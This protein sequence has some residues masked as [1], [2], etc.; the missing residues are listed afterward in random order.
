[1]MRRPE[2]PP[3]GQLAV[4]ERAGDRVDQRDLEQLGRGQ[5]RQN[6]G[7]ARGQH[8]LAGAGRPVEQQRVRPGGGDLERALGALLALDV[9]EVGQRAG[10]LADR[11]ARA[12]HHLRAGKVVGEL[13]QR[14][15]RQH[16]HVGRGPRR[17][18]PRLLRADQAEAASVGGHRRGQHAD[19]GGERA[20]Q[21]Q[22]AEHD[23]GRQ[24]VGRQG[25]DRRHD[26]ERDRQVVMTALLGQVGGRE[27]DD[28]ALGRQRQPRGE[29]RRAH[30]LLRFRDRLV[31]EADNAEIDV[32]ARYLDLDVD[33]ARLDPLERHGRNSNNH[34][35]RP[36]PKSRELTQGRLRLATG[37]RGAEPVRCRL[38]PRPSFE[39][40]R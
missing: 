35:A 13:D 6:R 34:R 2:R 22:L 1:M 21:R 11:R 40:R 30:P 19:D 3:V 23:V 37:R 36:T 10:R 20:I 33:R 8:R 25:A 27:V 18:G 28:D 24:H 9:G 38:Q 4:G 26:A 7:Q 16:V 17:L 32:A 15:R 14:A 39:W 29:Q 12:A 31:A 5:W